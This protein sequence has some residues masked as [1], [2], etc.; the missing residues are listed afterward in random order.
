MGSAPVGGGNS[1]Y[2]LLHCLRLHVLTARPVI[3]VRMWMWNW[4]YPF[5]WWLSFWRGHERSSAGDSHFDG[6]HY[7]LKVLLL[8][9]AVYG[10][11]P[12]NATAGLHG[13]VVVV[14][15]CGGRYL[16]F[17]WWGKHWNLQEGCRV[18]SIRIRNSKSSQ[19]A[20]WGI[21]HSQS[22]KHVCNNVA[23]VRLMRTVCFLLLTLLHPFFGLA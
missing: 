19:N 23:P 6:R 12:S 1:D 15:P 8:A 14:R 2:R 7:R 21:S 4:L 11:G 22:G 20:S 5:I 17:S 3:C 18:S 10:N 16:W 13:T 9:N